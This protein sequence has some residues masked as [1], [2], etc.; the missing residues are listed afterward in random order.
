M[1]LVTTLVDVQGL[2]Q[3]AVTRENWHFE[4]GAD[5]SE[6]LGVSF[7]PL[8]PLTV[9]GLANA[10]KAPRRSRQS[11]KFSSETSLSSNGMAGEKSFFRSCNFH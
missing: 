4:G 5:D 3:A 1:D 7:R 9:P 6:G 8:S 2:V 10:I 11:L